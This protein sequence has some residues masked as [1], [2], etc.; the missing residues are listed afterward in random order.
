MTSFKRFLV[1]VVVF[2]VVT[3]SLAFA[4]TPPS[5][6][7]LL[8]QV[9]ALQE[10]INALQE[11]QKKLQEQKHESVA[12]L[13]ATL[14]QGASGDQVAVLQALL[15]ADPS[16]YPEGV[17]SG[18][19]GPKTAAAVKRFQKKHGLEQVGNVGPKTLERLKEYLEEHPMAFATSTEDGR[20][21]RPC[22]IVPPGHMIAPGWLKKH[23]GEDRPRVPE[24]Q[25]LPP[26]ITDKLRDGWKRG[27]TTPPVASTTAQ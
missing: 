26:G 1:L 7:E 3:P 10:Q 25:N 17:I 16:I 20:K 18:T 23:E 8:A 13:V 2:G 12:T 14:K 4:Q 5:V 11:Q 6:T 19:Y 22:A 24:C 21:K 27:S 15:A 9:K